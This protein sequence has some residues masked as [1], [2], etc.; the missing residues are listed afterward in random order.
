[1]KGEVKG[2]G[3]PRS[4]DA[5]GC[6]ERCGSLKATARD[7]DEAAL[8]AMLAQVLFPIGEMETREPSC[9]LSLYRWLRR[10]VSDKSNFANL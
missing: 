10:Q 8:L 6:Y 7:E 1:M 2:Y 5:K 3:N 4:K 9:Q